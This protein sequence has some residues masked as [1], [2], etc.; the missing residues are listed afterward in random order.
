[1]R[2]IGIDVGINGAIAQISDRTNPALSVIDIPTIGDGPRRQVNV[3]ELGAWL[4]ARAEG[5]SVAF[6]ELAMAMPSFVGRT[7]ER[8]SMGASSAF[9]FGRAVGALHATVSLLGISAEIVHA[10]KWKIYFGLKGPDKENSRLLALQRFPKCSDLFKRKLDHQ[11]A[12][13][14]LIALYGWEKI[15]RGDHEHS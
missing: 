12:E 3:R 2:T 10:N 14:A 13:A 6:I 7:G 5:E 8:Q 15:M 11:R 9:N 1:M 4:H